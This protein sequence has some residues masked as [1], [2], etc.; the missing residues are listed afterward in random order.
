MASRHLFH[1]IILSR[2]FMIRKYYWLHLTCFVFECT[3]QRKVQ[4]RKDH[5]DA[6]EMM[7]YGRTSFRQDGSLELISSA[8]HLGFSFVGNECSVM[9][10]IPLWLD[11]NYLQYE[12]DGVYQR[13]LRVGQDSPTPIKISALSEGKHIVWVFKATEAATGPVYIRNIIGN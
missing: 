3:N 4:G 11:H 7:P 8:V 13:R 12:L 1:Q 10:S 5:L 9:A 6:N 2:M